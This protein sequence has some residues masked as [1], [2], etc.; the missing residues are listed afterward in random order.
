MNFRCFSFSVVLLSS[1]GN[2]VESLYLLLHN[3]HFNSFLS[4]A[5][6]SRLPKVIQYTTKKKRTQ[7]LFPVQFT[8]LGSSNLI[9]KICT[10]GRFLRNFSMISLVLESWPISTSN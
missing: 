2:S 7:C 1:P 5:L 9:N 6:A 3:M 4:L 10:T 8:F